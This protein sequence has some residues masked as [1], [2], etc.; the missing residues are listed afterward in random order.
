MRISHIYLANERERA[1]ERTRASF[2]RERQR[3]F[4]LEINYYLHPPGRPGPTAWSSDGSNLQCII[5]DY[6]TLN[7]HRARNMSRVRERQFVFPFI[8]PSL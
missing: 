3:A 1:S 4:K 6:R 7:V 2:G 8:E 5:L